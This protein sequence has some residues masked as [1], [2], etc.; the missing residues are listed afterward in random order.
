M[1]TLR[2]G[3]KWLVNNAHAVAGFGMFTAHATITKS[4]NLVALAKFK[5]WG[6]AF[7]GTAGLALT[8]FPQ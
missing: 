8:W 7:R 5:K 6:A 3:N 1:P 4:A 2:E